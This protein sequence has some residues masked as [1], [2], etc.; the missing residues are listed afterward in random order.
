MSGSSNDEGGPDG[1]E[2]LR[3][4][5]ENVADFA[6]FAVDPNGVVMSWNVGAERLLGYSKTEIVGCDGDMIF[7]P[8]DR[9]N[10]V[11]QEERLRAR[12][13]G[14]AEDERWH[15][16]KN[17]VRFWASGLLMPLQGSDNFAKIFRD[18]TAEHE[19]GEQLRENEERFRLLA[20]SIPQLVFRSRPTG[21]RTWGS[22]QWEVFAGLSDAQSRSFGWLDAIHPEDIEETV[23]AWRQASSAG[24]YFVEHRIR[25]ASD[26]SFRWHQTHAKPTVGG[27]TADG[28]WVGTSTD[29]HDLRNLNERQT[30][31]VY[32]LQHRTR[33]LLALVQSI[34][35]QTM[36]RSDTLEAFAPAFESRLRA[37]SRVQ[38]LLARPNEHIIDLRGLIEAEIAAHDHGDPGKVALKGPSV[39]VPREAAQA[40]ALALHE[41]ATNAVKYGALG[42]PDGAL[43]VDWTLDDRGPEPQLTV[44]WRETGVALTAGPPPR[45]GYG[46]ELIE[47][48]LRYQLDAE[49]TL[50][51]THGGVRCTISVPLRS[52]EE[53]DGA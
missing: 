26:G 13:M 18:R 25:R 39:A 23:E 16:R 46:S 50:E 3:L 49:T 11:P 29:I 51:F 42:R 21:E 34:A 22:P 6:I 32:E 48:A 41:L 5:A 38:G 28:D 1:A 17:G 36:R 30:V 4:I 43:T 27:A 10:G 35:H 53:S 12:R 45:R 15:L 40:L 52:D 37:L 24:E 2:L 31:L 47:R 33:N 20:T 9:A 8:E 44:Q 14:R 19:A 7:T